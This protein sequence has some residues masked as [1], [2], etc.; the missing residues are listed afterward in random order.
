MAMS[1]SRSRV[2]SLSSATS[3]VSSWEA[4]NV[5]S[6]PN[7]SVMRSSTATVSGRTS[8]SIWFR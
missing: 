6:T 5:A 2:T 3:R 4:K 1:R 8:C 7:T